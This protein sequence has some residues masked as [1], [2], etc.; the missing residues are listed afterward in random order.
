MPVLSSS[1]TVC[2]AA[3]C[4]TTVSAQCNL[5]TSI[6]QNNG[7]NGILFDVA[8]VGAATIRISSIDLGAGSTTLAMFADGHLIFVN[9]VAV[10]GHHVTFDIARTLSTPFA[11]AERIKTLHGSVEEEAAEDEELF[12]YA[13]SSGDDAPLHETTKADLNGII[14]T[15][16]SDLLSQAT[17]RIDGSGV[18][19]LSGSHI[20]LTGG[21]AL[22]TD[23]DKLLTEE[24][25]LPVVIADEPLTCVARGGGRV[26]ELLDEYGPSAF[27]VE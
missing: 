4:T 12:S 17:A 22:L 19:H 10:G 15:R 3:V 25:G 8:N 11:E 14:A 18:A 26:L 2:S 23:I 9:T 16:V 6:V 7:L 20:V 21:G 5:A 13:V 24:T 1:V 27:S